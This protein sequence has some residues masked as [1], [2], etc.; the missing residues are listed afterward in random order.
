MRRQAARH[1]IK[2]MFLYSPNSTSMAHV[3]PPAQ[4]GSASP[5]VGRTADTENFPVGSRLLPAELRPTVAAYYRLARAAYDIADNPRLD[6][7]DKVRRLDALDAILAGRGAAD[8]R[9]PAQDAAAR[10]PVLTCLAKAH[11]ERWC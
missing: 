3:S 2:E 1:A 7:Q 6:G 8:G 11:S 5:Y 9:D 4:P 10:L